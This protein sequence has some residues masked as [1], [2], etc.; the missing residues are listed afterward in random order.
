MAARGRLFAG[1]LLLLSLWL[2]AAGCSALPNQME[3][4]ANGTLVYTQ[5]SDTWSWVKANGE[6]TIQLNGKDFA[7]VRG[8]EADVTLPD[9]RAVTV[10]LNG[11]NEPTSAQTKWGVLLSAADYSTMDQ[12]FQFHKLAGGV[13]RAIPWVG[14][15]LLFLLILVAILAS[16]RA[17]V[18]VDWA[19]VHG[20][21]SSFNTGRM[22]FL[23][24]AVAIL[25]AVMFL[26]LLLVLLF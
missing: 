19:K 1:I 26:V 22:L 17:D 12:A 16:I 18:L 3:R 6:A 9:G 21:F 20:V 11:Q 14:V 2:L 8:T 10:E 7:T 4:T 5:G 23:T 15:V 25:L 13:G 24:R